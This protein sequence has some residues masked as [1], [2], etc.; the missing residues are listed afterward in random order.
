[1][2]WEMGMVCQVVDGEPQLL[3]LR[4]DSFFVLGVLLVT[5]DEAHGSILGCVV[6]WW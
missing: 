2:L 6:L 5:G 4:V 1:M 3:E